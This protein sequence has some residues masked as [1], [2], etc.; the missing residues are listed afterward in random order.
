MNER[1]IN[2]P[3]ACTII[4]QFG[5]YVAETIARNIDIERMGL[6]GWCLMMDLVILGRLKWN[7]HAGESGF[8]RLDIHDISTR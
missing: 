7:R 5:R 6:H 2:P 4:A 8:A 1:V 3:K